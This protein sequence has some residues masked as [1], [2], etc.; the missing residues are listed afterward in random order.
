MRPNRTAGSWNKMTRFTLIYFG[1]VALFALIMGPMVVYVSSCY[2]FDKV[3]FE[4][5]Y[6]N[7]IEYIII[8]MGAG[9]GYGGE[10]ELQ[11]W[12]AATYSKIYKPNKSL[13]QLHVERRRPPTILSVVKLVDLTSWYRWLRVLSDVTQVLTMWSICAYIVFI[14]CW[15]D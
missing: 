13:E 9:S 10:G 1:L 8:R 7:C 5:Y 3:G 11:G 4:L 14:G 15:I 12:P 2:L 6:P